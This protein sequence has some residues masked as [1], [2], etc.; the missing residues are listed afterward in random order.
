M[1][2]NRRESKPIVQH[3]FEAYSDLVFLPGMTGSQL[4]ALY[5]KVIRS[6]PAV[7]ETEEMRDKRSPIAWIQRNMAELKDANGRR[8]PNQALIEESM[9]LRSTEAKLYTSNLLSV[10]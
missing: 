9:K 4:N 2:G 3:F 7:N 1:P 8:M 6:P 10:C 5:D